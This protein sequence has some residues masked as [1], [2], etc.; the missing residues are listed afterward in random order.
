[1]LFAP[2]ALAHESGVTPTDISEADFVGP[3]VGLLII[4]IAIVIARLIR[5]GRKHK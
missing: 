3:V 4:S 2:Q 1:M 5:K